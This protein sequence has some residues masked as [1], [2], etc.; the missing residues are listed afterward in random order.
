MKQKE[1]QEITVE[2]KNILGWKAG[3]DSN[4]KNN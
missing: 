3:L 2:I 1:L 4:E